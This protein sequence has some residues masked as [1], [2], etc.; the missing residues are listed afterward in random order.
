VSIGPATVSDDATVIRS[1]PGVGILKA[2]WHCGGNPTG[3][4][5]PHD[6]PEC[7]RCQG[8]TCVA[9]DG[10]T[11]EQREGNCR[12]E[13]CRSG[14][15]G[16]ETDD[17]DTPRDLD[18]HDCMTIDCRDG[19]PFWRSTLDEEPE[20]IEGNCYRE[21]C[22]A[23]AREPDPGDPP[24]GMLCCID[25]DPIFDDV[26][27]YNP[28][29]QFCTPT[30]IKPQ[31]PVSLVSLRFGLCPDIRRREGFDWPAPP[32]EENE[33]DGCS[34]PEWSLPALEKLWFYS[35][36][37]DNPAGYDDTSFAQPVPFAPCF[38]HDACYYDCTTN[39]YAFFACNND[40]AVNLA[41]TCLAAELLHQPTCLIF[42]DLY[43]D[44]VAA[45]GPAV[46]PLSQQDACQCC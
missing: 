13:V 35:G 7:Q 14:A 36:D 39:Y 11:L 16:T 12:R 37:P 9:D 44:A 41:A 40:F 21:T 38:E 10:Q 20:Q 28:E 3:T 26:A 6:C 15:A 31:V 8:R 17:A 4:G 46:F 5:T 1:D 29:N 42:A 18:P 2:G 24:P 33:Y 30:G 25:D 34:V 43:S 19:R 27:P 45:A 22:P 32:G 23:P